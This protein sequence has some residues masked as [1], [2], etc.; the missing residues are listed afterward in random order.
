MQFL[1]DNFVVD[2]QGNG[3][4]ALTTYAS[5]AFN[6]SIRYG[7]KSSGD[8]SEEEREHYPVISIEDFVP[9]VM[10]DW[11]DENGKRFAAARDTNNDGVDDTITM[12][13]DAIPFNFRYEVS[14]A[15]KS[16]GEYYALLE[17]FAKTFE[18]KNGVFLFN[19]VT[20]PDD[21]GGPMA[22]YVNYDLDSRES[23]RTDG[24]FETVFIFVLYP[25]VA[26]KDQVDYDVLSQI[27]LT[28]NG[29]ETKTIN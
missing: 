17:W 1:G 9:T 8:Y 12:F 4:L 14:V 27:I 18:L 20:L 7:R 24:I 3:V 15:C 19:K 10:K 21:V 23:P 16:E 13:R 29:N 5:S 28:Y 11:Y 2:A 25:F 26:I 22:D 6:V